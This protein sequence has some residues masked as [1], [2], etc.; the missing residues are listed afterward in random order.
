MG[1]RRGGTLI[2]ALEKRLREREKEKTALEWLGPLIYCT[3]P[4]VGLHPLACILALFASTQEFAPLLQ[5]SSLHAGTWKEKRNKLVD[6]Q[7]NKWKEKHAEDKLGK[8]T[9]RGQTNM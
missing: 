3:L 7:R 6:K 4:S 1:T 8:Y 9:K 2:H 5:A